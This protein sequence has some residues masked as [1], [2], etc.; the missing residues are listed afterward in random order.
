M[1]I[2]YHFYTDL[3]QSLLT[4]V[5]VVLYELTDKNPVLAVASGF[6]VVCNPSRRFRSDQTASISLKW[7][8]N[9]VEPWQT[10]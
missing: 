3:R 10:P 1:F 6:S 5:V 2:F 8:C 7:R 4:N 9:H